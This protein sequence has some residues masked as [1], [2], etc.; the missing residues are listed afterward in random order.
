[1]RDRAA[2]RADEHDVFDILMVCTGNICRSPMAE[3][4]LADALSGA[5]DA[6]GRQVFR[7]HS[8]GTYGLHGYPIDA[9]AGRLMTDRGI[10]PS[11]FRAREITASMVAEADLVLTATREH[12]AHVVTLHPRSAQRTFTIREFGRLCTG[13]D[14]ATLPPGDAVRRARAVVAAAAA[15]RGMFTA[16]RHEDDVADPYGARLTAFEASA[17]LITEALALP[18]T[19]LAGDQARR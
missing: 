6:S 9:H 17:A 5:V 19:L 18:V 13:I 16:P 14:P 8:A 3:L 10:D 7:V 1:M 11:A 12:R 4:I 2:R 15:Q